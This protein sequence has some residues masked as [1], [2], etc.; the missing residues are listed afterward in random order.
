MILTTSHRRRLAGGVLLLALVAAPIA[1]VADEDPNLG[2]TIDA[3]QETVEGE[4]VLDVGH[5][6]LGPR[7]VDGQWRLLIH[8][9]AA[10]AD[11]A[12]TSV[13]RFPEQTV[14]HVLDPARR[15]VPDDPAY[16]F[17][18]AEPGADVWVVPQTQDPEVVWLG[19]NTQDPE[20]MATIDRG[21]TMSLAGVQ[22]RGVVTMYLQSGSFGEPQLLWDSRVAD[23]QPVWVEMNTHTHANWV[24]T[25]PGVYLLRVTVS[26]TLIGGDEVA[27]TRDLRFA[28]GTATD[29]A[30]AL[31]A[32]WEEAGAEPDPEEV[33]DGD[34][35]EG[36]VA[37]DGEV[38]AEDGAF[39]VTAV[40]AVVAAGLA[41]ALIVTVVRGRAAQRRALDRAGRGED[42]PGAGR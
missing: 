7:Y 2:Q 4:R 32:R 21:V 16:A 9:D 18:G 6:D 10:K 41:V 11:E 24:F 23:P 3:E 14:L 1:A 27:D 29:P 12:A 30:A 33:L 38:A 34:G 15:P 22:G 5:V 19:W 17:T 8:D 35:A 13:W 20:V 28:V 39:P 40:L 36:E 37:P 26:A 42:G 25:E 31:A